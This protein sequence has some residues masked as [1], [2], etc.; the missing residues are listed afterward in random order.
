MEQNKV[1]T[2]KQFIEQENKRLAEAREELS[3][4]IDLLPP[5]KITIGRLYKALSKEFYF[6]TSIVKQ[7]TPEQ[8]ARAGEIAVLLEA[9][10]KVFP[11]VITKLKKNNGRTRKI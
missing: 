1:I 9:A 5:P 6:L 8:D 7:T 11:N 2:L 4:K 10:D 3:D